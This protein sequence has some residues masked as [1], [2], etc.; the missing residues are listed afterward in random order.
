MSSSDRI[1]FSEIRHLLTLDER[2]VHL[3]L[4]FSALSETGVRRSRGFARLESYEHDMVEKYGPR[5]DPSRVFHAP[6]RGL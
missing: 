2:R 5:V 6:A 4:R 3:A 1:W